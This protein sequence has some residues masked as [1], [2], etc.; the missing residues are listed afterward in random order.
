MTECPSY[1][2]SVIL[3][4]SENKY[5]TGSLPNIAVYK[6]NSRK[7]VIVNLINKSILNLQRLSSEQNQLFNQAKAEAP[8][9]VEKIL[10]G[11]AIQINEKGEEESIITILEQAQQLDR[12]TIIQMDQYKKNMDEFMNKVNEMVKQANGANLTPKKL[13][14]MLKKVESESSHLAGIAKQAQKVLK[15][16]ADKIIGLF[17]KI[18]K[19]NINIYKKKRGISIKKILEQM[20]LKS[21]E[22][23][24]DLKQKILTDELKRKEL[25]NNLAQAVKDSRT[26]NNYITVSELSLEDIKIALMKEYYKKPE[27]FLNGFVSL[28]VKKPSETSNR[29]QVRH[30]KDKTGSDAIE[31]LCS[32]GNTLITQEDIDQYGIEIY[33]TG[34]ATIRKT[35]SLEINNL[36]RKANKKKNET[37][38]DVFLEDFNK[39][40]YSPSIEVKTTFRADKPDDVISF[41]TKKGNRFSFQFSDKLIQEK[42]GY[43]G[44]GGIQDISIEDGSLF[45]T[46]QMLKNYGEISNEKELIFL[47][48]NM[49]SVSALKEQ[50]SA[51]DL[52]KFIKMILVSY[53]YLYAFNPQ[54]QQIHNELANISFVEKNTIY[55]HHVD[56]GIIPSYVLLQKTIQ[57]LYEMKK[58]LEILAT[59]DEFIKVLITPSNSYGTDGT[60]ILEYAYKQSS[61][62]N[63]WDIVANL[64][65]Y[66]TT[67]DIAINLFALGY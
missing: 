32:F 1:P 59:T 21:K 8:E 26:N 58:N 2:Y 43:L 66:D 17:K 39:K 18:P 63:P 10:N 6:K 9:L 50:T 57:Q 45:S 19:E 62:S 36:S 13:E 11:R 27:D 23:T 25:I 41:L 47:L 48:L 42:S 14:T 16:D 49:S 60:N 30:S 31:I 40:N 5:A 53:I 44:R 22:T 28:T 51:P 7:G 64:I 37:N 20:A 38:F 24:D 52:Q 33:Q 35:A 61:N 15:T 67:L 12:D 3:N 29:Q 46:I 55:F 54:A 56:T 4:V 65:S 34:R